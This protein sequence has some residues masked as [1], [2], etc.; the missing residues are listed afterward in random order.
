ML[1]IHRG[2][3]RRA[4]SAPSREALL[5][6]GSRLAY[7]ELNRRANRAAHLL[8]RCGIARGDRVAVLL[9]RSVDLVVTV[10]AVLKCG[11]S[12]V[13]LDPAYPAERTAFVIADAQARAV[14]T[15]TAL[16]SALDAA[17]AELLLLDASAARLAL[18][19]ATNPAVETSARDLAYVIYTSGSTGR[20]KGVMI[21]HAAACARLNWARAAFSDDELGGMLA[22]TSIC[23]DLSVFE[24]FAPLWCGGRVLLASNALELPELPYRDEVRLVNTVP[25]A[26]RALLELDALPAGVRTVCLAGEQ[27]PRS[28]ARA[29]GARRHVTR[30]L[31]LYGPTEDT[32]YSTCAEV[33][34]DGDEP[35][36]IGRPLP[37]TRAYVLDESGRRCPAGVAGE[38]H[39][40]GAGLARGYWNRPEQTAERFVRDA[41]SDVA[42]ARMYRTGDRVRAR[43]DGELESVGRLDDQVKVRGYRVELG[44]IEHVLGRHPGAGQCAVA[45]AGL[46]GGDSRLVAYYT[47]AAPEASLREQSRRRAAGVHGAGVVRARAADPAHAERKAGPGAPARARSH[48]AGRNRRA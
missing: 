21:E 40:G 22:S 27:F 12:Y 26:M 1:A 37:G 11:A 14:V 47:G 20:P 24:I 8:L 38:L 28:I 34:P 19:P 36:P 9:P 45:L 41:F 42:G 5:H 13:P 44:E 32:T 30:I 4:E 43:E 2:F 7:D 18:Q 46:P 17:G 10:L 48:A 6:A 15:T 3:E 29:L 35:P 31:N 16:A 39:L 25:S 23:F 33:R